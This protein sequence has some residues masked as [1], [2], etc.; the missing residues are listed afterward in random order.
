MASE[1]GSATAAGP[2]ANVNVWLK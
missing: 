2:T 1:T